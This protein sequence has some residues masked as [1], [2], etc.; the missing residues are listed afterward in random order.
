MVRERGA[1]RFPRENAG[2]ASLWPRAPTPPPSANGRRP[3]CSR[4]WRRTSSPSRP[5]ARAGR[6]AARRRRGG[7]RHSPADTHLRNCATV[8][9]VRSSHT[10]RDNGGGGYSSEKAGS[11]QTFPQGSA[12]HVFRAATISSG[13]EP[14]M[15]EPSRKRMASGPGV[16]RA[17]IPLF[18]LASAR[19][20]TGASSLGGGRAAPSLGL[21]PS[22]ARAMTVAG[23][24]TG[25]RRSTG[26]RRRERALSRGELGEREL[27]RV[28]AERA[29]AIVEVDRAR[30]LDG[31]EDPASRVGRYGGRRLV[32]VVAEVGRRHELPAAVVARDEGVE[33]GRSAWCRRSS[34]SP[35]IRLRPRCRPCWPMATP[36]ALSAL[37]PPMMKLRTCWPLGVSSSAKTSRFWAPRMPPPKIHV[38]PDGPARDGITGGVRGNRITA[39]RVL[40]AVSFPVNDVSARVDARDEEV[41]A[42]RAREHGGAEIQG[43]PGNRP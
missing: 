7:L 36:P 43:I 40:V 23:R 20:S 10:E 16:R 18:V 1:P 41:E 4:H 15:N 42:S 13:V 33:A 9:S 5:A 6:S 26:R 21:E 38:A 24:F 17:T 3:R 19:V 14:I 35:G 22:S 28:P 11:G 12:S 2:C 29:G 8:T 25:T 27:G 37:L 32:L 39:L 31:H 34:P 30:D